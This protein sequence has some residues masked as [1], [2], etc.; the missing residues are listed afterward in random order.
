MLTLNVKLVKK[1]SFFI[2]LFIS[3]SVICLSTENNVNL[4]VTARH[5]LCHQITGVF[6]NVSCS[7]S[8]EHPIK[9]SVEAEMKSLDTGS[10]IRDRCLRSSRFFHVKQYPSCTFV[11]THITSI[12]ENEYQVEGDLCLKGITKN[13][14]AHMN[15]DPEIPDQFQLQ[16]EI[17]RLDFGITV[18]ALL[19]MGGFV[20][21]RH[22]RITLESH[23]HSE[24]DITL[25]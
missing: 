16:A 9:I 25:Y 8:H 21:G 13:I 2:L 4:S 10:A 5:M 6:H 3:R 1:L 20:V 11:S 22:V 7:F 19:E 12:N 24:M 14:T 15:W 17:D 23:T 18:G